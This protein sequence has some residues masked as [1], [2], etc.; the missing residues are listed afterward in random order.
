[1][2]LNDPYLA[3]YRQQQAGRG[4]S[5]VFRGAAFQ[6]GHGL[7]S[8][9]AGMMRTVGPLIRS[10]A[11]TL[12]KEALRTGVGFLGDVATGTSD[13]RAAANARLK[14][15]TETLKRKAD[16]KLERVL[17]GGGYKRRRIQRVTPQ[18]LAKLLERK[19]TKKRKPSK[20]KT[21]LRKKTAVRRKKTAVKRRRKPVKDIF[22]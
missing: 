11:A 9:L 18:S 22:G 12:G 20:K 17:S 4:V 6:R 7:G 2:N 3:Y 13:P 16:N 5:S 19:T 1:M 15:F 14:R 8:F 10:G 21:V